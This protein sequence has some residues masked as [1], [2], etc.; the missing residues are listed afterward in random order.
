MNKDNFEGG[1]RS[2]V[3]QGER[4]VGAELTT[5]RRRLKAHT[6]RLRAALRRLGA[7]QRTRRKKWPIPVQFPI[8]PG[9]ATTSQG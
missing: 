3:G 1:V 7:A 2:A 4:S 6:I 8:C 9:C 5:K